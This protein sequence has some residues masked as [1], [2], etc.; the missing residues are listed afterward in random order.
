MQA[1]LAVYCNHFQTCFFLCKCFVQWRQGW[2]L[3]L[4]SWLVKP[5]SDRVVD[6]APESKPKPWVYQHVDSLN[7]IYGGEFPKPYYVDNSC[8]RNR[9]FGTHP[10]RSQLPERPLGIGFSLPSNG[11]RTLEDTLNEIIPGWW[12]FTNPFAKYESNWIISP[13]FGV[14]NKYFETI[15]ITQD[16][17][18]GRHPANQ[19]MFVVFPIIHR[20]FYIQTVVGN[21]IS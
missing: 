3:I 17:V 21:G 19:L 10:S 8:H 6:L 14:K 20:T 15:R 5:S 2:L 9:E 13:I 1:F 11:F 12:F 4:I 7:T 18:N 16:T